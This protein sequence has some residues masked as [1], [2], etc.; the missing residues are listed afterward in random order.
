MKSEWKFIGFDLGAESGRCIVAVLSNNKI[1]LNEVHRFATTCI[2]YENG[3]YW[4]VLAIYQEIIEGLIKAKKEFGPDLDGIG[5]DTWGVDY[6]LIDSSGRI[7]GY[8]YHYRDDRTDG[9]MDE[10][11]HIVSKETLYNKTG[12]QPAQYNTLFQLLSEKKQKLN[13]LN[14]ADKLLLMPDFFNYMLSGIIKS[15]FTIAST[16]NLTDP[17]TRNWSKEL[18]ELFDL[19]KNIFPDM[20]E[21][22]KRLGNLLPSISKKTGLNSEIP[23]F[24][25]AGH[26]T[27]SA[28]VSIPSSGNNWAFISS[29][30]WSLIGI[31]TQKPLINSKGLKNNF[32]T[33]GGVNGT[34]QFL[35]NII[36]LWPLQECRRYWQEKGTY[37]SYS[38]LADLAKSENSIGSWIDLNN[39]RFLKPG[40]MPEKII[41]YFLETGQTFKSNEGFIVKTILESLAFSYKKTIKEIEEITGKN[42][43]RLHIVG[44]GIKNELLTQLTADATGKVVYAGPVE[45]AIIGNIAIQAIATGA[46]PNVQTF[47]NIITNSFE[48]RTYT[49]SNVDYFNK[50]EINYEKILSK[51]K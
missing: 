36:G 13:L 20:I 22:G 2:Q 12:N 42:I 27:A 10:A 35:K 16:T 47:H 51:S 33:E 28:V 44:G 49:P 18:I 21:P 7:L 30:T 23:V 14:I 43:D 5:I 39:P 3:F 8:P 26:D 40:E 48:I 50:N 15:E 24:T 32:T 31:E 29:G 34:T 37:F 6:V 11:F 46:V 4:D 41:Q 9:I 1:T 17:F 25:I 45:G 38:E 19:P